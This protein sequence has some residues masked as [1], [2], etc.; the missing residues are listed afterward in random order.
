MS[1]APNALQAGEPLGGEGQEA[2]CCLVVT[3]PD[4]PQ[5]QV[6]GGACK[7]GPSQGRTAQWVHACAHVAPGN[8]TP[9]LGKLEPPGELPRPAVRQAQSRDSGTSPPPGRSRPV[10]PRAQEG[11]HRPPCGGRSLAQAPRLLSSPAL[12]LPGRAG[13]SSRTRGMPGRSW[14]P[15]SMRRTR[16]PS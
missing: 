1:Q 12:T 3:Q 2:H 5:T 11:W 7:Q 10:P 8:R 9:S 13:S 4:S 15:G 14:K 16:C 6:R